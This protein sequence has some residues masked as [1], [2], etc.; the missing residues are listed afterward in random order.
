MNN[1][2][3]QAEWGQLCDRVRR[4]AE[5]IAEND[6][7]KADFLQQA[8]TFANQDPPQ[9]YSELLQSTAEASRLAIGW[10]Q[11]CDADTAYEAKVLHEEEMLDET[12]DESFPA[13]DPPS[14]SHGHA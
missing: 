8:E 5:A 9:T 13:S 12:L 7:E 10:Q 2:F 6:V 4:C 11:K 1:S 14:F 3:T